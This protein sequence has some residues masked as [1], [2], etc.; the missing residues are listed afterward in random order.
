MN[1]QVLGSHAVLCP[2]AYALYVLVSLLLV[3]GLRAYRCKHSHR[4]L[5]IRAHLGRPVVLT[6]FRVDL[7]DDFFCES[8]LF[9][10]MLNQSQC[11]IIVC[12]RFIL[13]NFLITH[14]RNVKE[15]ILLD[16][17]QLLFLKS[18]FLYFTHSLHQR[19]NV[20]SLLIQPCLSV[21]LLLTA[22]RRFCVFKF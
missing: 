20:D 21:L 8:V 15:T 10:V 4:G 9:H 6:V 1:R 3:S 2:H 14:V 22:L 11:R 7:V 16:F 18:Y 5:L 13:F 17:F 12:L 19:R